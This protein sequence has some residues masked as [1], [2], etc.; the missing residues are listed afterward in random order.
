MHTAYIHIYLYI[1]TLQDKKKQTSLLLL[2]S[3]PF[4]LFFLCRVSSSLSRKKNLFF[5]IDYRDRERYGFVRTTMA[6]VKSETQALENHQHSSMFASLY[7]GDLSP[8]VTEQDLI[9]RFSLTVPVL[10][11][12]LCRNSVTGKSLCYAY[13]NF[14]SPFSGKQRLRLFSFLRSKISDFYFIV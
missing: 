6:L 4:T 1:Y 5:L 9:H 11:V 7:V 12:H 14:D 10:S 3:S 8:D 13:I 2:S